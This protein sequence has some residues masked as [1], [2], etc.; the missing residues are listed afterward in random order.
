MPIDLPKVLT[1]IEVSENP[2][3]DE[4]EA[5]TRAWAR[6]LG[7]DADSRSAARLAQVRLGWYSGLCWPT[8][9][10]EQLK[11]CTDV[12]T[13]LFS[14][15]D[16]FDQGELAHQPDEVEHIAGAIHQHVFRAPQPEPSA[17]AW[18]LSDIY[19][20]AQAT[21]PL[22]WSRRLERHVAG[23]FDATVKAAA[24]RSAGP[25]PAGEP[26]DFLALWRD[27]HAFWIALDF[28][29]VVLGH[30]FPAAIYHSPPIQELVRLTV[31][32]SCVV[33][34]LFSLQD[35]DVFNLRLHLQRSRGCTLE[36]ATAQAC[37][38]ADEWTAQFHAAYAGLP[39]FLDRLHSPAET[40]AHAL[41]YADGL[42]AAFRGNAE[43][44]TAMQ[45]ARYKAAVR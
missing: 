20:R 30:A 14:A 6:E 1:A 24:F 13:W 38:L 3:A 9:S 34:D 37:A 7:L 33:N 10:A 42:R 26:D 39:Q 29:E 18:A 15:D 40:R 12:A 32:L 31:N 21:M 5:H 8:A 28:S 19:S 36:E 16:Y 17:L 44:T 23:F 35:N 43:W 45:T 2:Y 25:Q 22:F 11:L 41:D 27:Y 4:A